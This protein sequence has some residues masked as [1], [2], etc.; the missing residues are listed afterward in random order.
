MSA[1]VTC[2]STAQNLQGFKQSKCTPHAWCFAC[3]ILSCRTVTV[4]HSAVIIDVA[5][6]LSVCKNSYSR[7]LDSSSVCKSSLFIFEPPIRHGRESSRPSLVRKD[8]HGTRTTSTESSIAKSGSEHPTGPCKAPST[9]WRVNDNAQDTSWARGTQVR[10]G[11][12][13]TVLRTL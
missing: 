11:S 2:Q 1:L 9:D 7:P 8:R 3:I 4:D 10:N 6:V 5:A 13:I 12:T